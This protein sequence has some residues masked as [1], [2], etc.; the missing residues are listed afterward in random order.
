[1]SKLAQF[2]VNRRLTQSAKTYICLAHL[3]GSA[4]TGEIKACAAA[5]GAKTAK[6]WNVAATFNGG[7]DRVARV[8]GKWTLLPVGADFVRQQGYE[9][10]PASQKTAKK[11]DTFDVVIGHGRSPVWR[12]L[13]EW[14]RDNYELKVHEFNSQSVVGLTNKERL[15]SLVDVGDVALL[16]MT[17]EDEAGDGGVRARQNV[18]HEVGLFQGA[19]GFENAVILLEEDCDE[20]SNIAGLGQIRYASGKIE[21]A[22]EPLRKYLKER[23]SLT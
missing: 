19:L 23:H 11:K 14:L 6:D 10:E 16:V 12:E 17:A 9:I 4:T 22:F 8:D 21:D 18:V 7:G 1:M 2:M 5:N 20:F 13:K 15:Q 3:G